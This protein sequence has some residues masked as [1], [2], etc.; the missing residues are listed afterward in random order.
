MRPHHDDRASAFRQSGA[1]R[2]KL[3]RRLFSCPAC[4]SHWV[5]FTAAGVVIAGVRTPTAGDPAKTA[6]V[7][8]LCLTSVD[9]D[10]LIVT[11]ST[12]D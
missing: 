2:D 9:D 11:Q 10:G 1:G 12:L 8:E 7:C 6:M 5:A 3:A 4:G